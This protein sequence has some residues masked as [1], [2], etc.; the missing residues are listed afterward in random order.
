MTDQETLYMMALT[1]VP[2]LS[3][4]NLHLLIDELGSASAIYE[5]RKNI[6]QVLPSASPKFLDGMGDFCNYLKRA[7]EEL[8]FCR[9]GKIRCLGL[10]DEDYPQRLKDCNDAPVLLYFRGSA[11]L[12]S[13]HIVSMVGTR[14]ITN[15]GKDLCRSFVRDLKQVCPDALVVSGLA[16]GVDVNCH[17]AALEQGLETVGVLA[18][19]LD[20]I[21]PRHHRETAKQMVDQGG[22]LTEYMSNTIIDKRNF[23]Q[24]NR[25]VAGVSDAVIVVES[26]TKGGS[27]IT[28]EIAQSYNRQVWAF[29]G[30]VFD[31]Y[32]SGC[33][34]LIFK[35]KASLLT[36]AE[37]FCLEMGWTDD[38][39]HQKQLSE[40][41][42]QE[43]FADDYSAEEQ[44]VL[45]ALA[46]DDSKQINVLAVETNI[47]I[48]E[49]SS[50]LFSLEMKGAVQSLVGGRYKLRR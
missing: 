17:R 19:G 47:A 22:L 31:T 26:A 5:N 7:E 34:M 10:N 42:Q 2:S 44:A 33:N 12:N 20:Q 40:G 25:I 6:K 41:I 28:A 27:L 35:N 1:Q 15:Y 23:V 32:S 21:Y 39:Q 3:L 14:Q 30:R 46:R 18:H 37:D 49:L 4:T 8:E 45:Q 43:L 13:Q 29:P 38:V 11:N 24:R 48:G 36:N 16:Y 50:L 9:K